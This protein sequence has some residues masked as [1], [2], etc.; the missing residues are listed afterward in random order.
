MPKGSFKKYVRW[1]ER[2]GVTKKG[3]QTNRGEGGPSIGVRSHFLKKYWDFS[4]EF[5]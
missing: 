1:G 2:E 5:L 4:N 3:A